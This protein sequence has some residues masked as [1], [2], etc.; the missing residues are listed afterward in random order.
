MARDVILSK[1][2]GLLNSASSRGRE[3]VRRRSHPAEIC[4]L[5]AS[6]WPTHIAAVQRLGRTGAATLARQET[7]TTPLSVYLWEFE[8]LCHVKSDLKTRLS[9][10]SRRSRS[11]GCSNGQ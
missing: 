3:S 4:A 9:R 8:R 1:P 6:R 10:A 2:A 11:I 5:A 7:I